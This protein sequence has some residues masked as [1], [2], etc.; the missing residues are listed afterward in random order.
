VS[1]DICQQEAIE[2]LQ[3][4]PASGSF[5]WKSDMRRGLSGRSAGTINKRY[6][7]LRIEI[8]G[9]AYAAH[10]LAW[11]IHYGEWPSGY[12]DHINRN[13]LD[14]RIENLRSVTRAENAQNSRVP[15]R[16]SLTGVLG[17]GY[18]PAQ[19]FVAR[20]SVGG[21]SKYLVAF[22]TAEAAQSAYL[23]AKR[24]LHPSAFSSEAGAA[25]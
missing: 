2:I 15:R 1:E 11:L 19:G 9:K 8:N 13:R 20:I 21:I 22:K 12:V 14:N 10:R 6:G 5:V 3:Y 23:S 25:C 7:Y 18:R 24:H 4:D 16:N 17:V